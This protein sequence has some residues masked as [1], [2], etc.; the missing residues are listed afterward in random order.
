M[1]VVGVAEKSPADDA[2]IKAGDEVLA[3]DGESVAKDDIVSLGR[4][5]EG[6]PGSAVEISLRRGIRTQHYKLVRR[7]LL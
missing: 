3:L 2:G 5:L 7:Q 4:R 1:R 6:K